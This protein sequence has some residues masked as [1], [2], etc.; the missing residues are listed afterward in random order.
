MAAFSEDARTE[1]HSTILSP[2][3]LPKQA[4]S[5]DATQASFSR[6]KA[7]HWS[8]RAEPLATNPPRQAGLFPA[9]WDIH[10]EPALRL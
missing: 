10:R 7:L 1:H 9:L 4:R 3:A 5:V 2:Q 6:S 8:A